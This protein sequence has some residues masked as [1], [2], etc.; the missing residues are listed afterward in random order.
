[1]GLAEIVYLDEPGP[2][3]ATQIDTQQ[4]GMLVM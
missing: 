3:I 2:H 4:L 1:M